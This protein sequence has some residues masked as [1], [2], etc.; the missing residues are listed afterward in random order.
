MVIFL[1]GADDYQREAKK[2]EIM[3]E[4]RKK[5]SDLGL[6]TF[7]FSEDRGFEK[8]HE[9]LASQSLFQPKKI[10]S[11]DSAFE[12]DAKKLARVLKGVLENKDITVLISEKSKPIKAL[13]FLLKKPVLVQEFEILKEAE[14][15][16]FVLKEVRSRGLALEPGAVDFLAQVY[17]GN[18]WG[19]VT[20]LEKIQHL[21]NPSTS[22]RGSGQTG[23]GFR[24]EIS[25]RDLE[26]LG[27]EQVPNFWSLLLGFRSRDLGQR[28]WALEKV[29]ETKE[30]PAKIF[31]ILAYQLSD[32]LKD[33]AR[34]DLMVKSGRLEYEEVLV[35]LVL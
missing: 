17:N 15:R 18:S 27:M 25:V 30:P 16:K 35:D 8:F 13:D 23:P 12:V 2:W 7:D 28:L 22:R 10:A 4:F 19:L 6:A 14:W 20:E 9:F 1:Y 34:Y 11:V 21:G 31:N 24:V 29:F 3:A 26:E 32:R 33:F 5:R